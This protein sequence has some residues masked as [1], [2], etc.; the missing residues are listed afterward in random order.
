MGLEVTRVLA[1]LPCLIL[2]HVERAATQKLPLNRTPV[3]EGHFKEFEAGRN[4]SP[5]MLGKGG[6]RDGR[7]R[8]TR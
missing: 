5:G 2:D 4:L 8:A 7:A 1:C 6:G 3:C